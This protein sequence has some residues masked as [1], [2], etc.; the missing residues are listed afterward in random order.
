MVLD[1][2]AA[3]LRRSKMPRINPTLSRRHGALIDQMVVALARKQAP[4]DQEVASLL[5]AYDDEV[6]HQEWLNSPD[7]LPIP[8]SVMEIVNGPRM[9]QPVPPEP[10]WMRKLF[11]KLDD[12]S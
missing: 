5:Q 3:Q 12:R 9:G 2:T 6:A 11:S 1:V 4:F 8:D 7:F 10:G